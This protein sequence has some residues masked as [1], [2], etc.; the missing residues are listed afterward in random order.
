MSLVKFVDIYKR[1]V[2]VNPNYVNWVQPRGDEG[3]SVDICVGDK[4]IAVSGDI[5]TVVTALNSQLTR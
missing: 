2:H 1:E 3:K 4:V 5:N